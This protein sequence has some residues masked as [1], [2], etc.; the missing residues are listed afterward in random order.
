M[1]KGPYL[2]GIDIGGTGSKAGV[3]TLDGK[4]AGE[5]YGEYL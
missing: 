2:L 5:G 4:L 3:F 1:G